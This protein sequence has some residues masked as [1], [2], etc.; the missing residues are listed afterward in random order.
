MA[1][2][3]FIELEKVNSQ[4]GF[5]T[6][7][8]LLLQTPLYKIFINEKSKC[9]LSKYFLNLIFNVAKIYILKNFTYFSH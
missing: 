8:R 6:K 4:V 1:R 5:K 7:K 9:L 2:G 3:Y